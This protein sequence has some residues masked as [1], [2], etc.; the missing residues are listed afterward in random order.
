M[1]K[2]IISVVLSGLLFS[3]NGSKGPGNV[4]ISSDKDKILYAMGAMQGKSS[5]MLRLTKEEIGKI[6][7]GYY[8]SA[9]GEKLVVNIDDQKVMR[10]F[11]PKIQNF[12]RETMGKAGSENKKIGAA[13]IEK[14]LKEEGVKK[15][16][17]G[18]AYKVIKEGTG[19][20]PKATDTVE[21]HYHGTLIDGTV[22]DSSVDRKKTAKFPLNAVIKGWTEGLQLMK[23]GGKT[24]FVIPSELAY[25][26][27]GAGPSSKIEGGSTLIFDVELIKV[28]A[29][30]GAGHSAHDGHDHG[31]KDLKKKINAAVK[32]KAQGAKKIIKGGNSDQMKLKK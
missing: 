11:Q 18:L 15:T 17:S 30:S 1:K 8:D 13:Y 28:G 20:T 23:E 4:K 14:F 6:Y 16:E 31:H 29:D 9:T 12:F 24:K 25:G 21:V 7:K 27:N 32:A 2:V 19:K 5:K 26:D 3:C 22:F 10:E